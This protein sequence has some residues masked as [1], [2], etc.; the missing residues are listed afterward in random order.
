MDVKLA[1][2]I[3]TRGFVFSETIFST[4]L[5]KEIPEGSTFHL[6]HGMPIPDVFNYL[7]K[8]AL[9]TEC[10]HILF[11][12]DDME[13]PEGGIKKMIEMI[14]DGSRYVAID[15]G[16]VFNPNEHGH[17]CVKRDKHNT[18]MYT[19]TGCTMVEREI[20][21]Y[22]LEKFVSRWFST[23][24]QFVYEAYPEKLKMVKA[25]KAY[26]GH[27]IY[28]CYNLR[29]EGVRLDVVPDMR[30]KHVRIKNFERKL[31]NNGTYEKAYI[32]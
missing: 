16:L 21:E 20:F 13:I 7:V 30:C 14:N 23:D 22:E 8:E 5:N 15:Y 12:E 31:V 28:F 27:D 25:K 32:L 19:G 17:T 9:K 24:Y 29:M 3:P 11:V 10:T 18:V 4:F 26:G 1:V 2:C 6:A